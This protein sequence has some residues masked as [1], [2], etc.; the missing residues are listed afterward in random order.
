MRRSPVDCWRRPRR[1]DGAAYRRLGQC[2]DFCADH[3]QI[4]EDHGGLHRLP[5]GV[6][7]LTE[8]VRVG[9]FGIDDSRV[10]A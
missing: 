2:S 7:A 6:T 9:R 8:R 5:A 1:D 4:V 3:P 10:M